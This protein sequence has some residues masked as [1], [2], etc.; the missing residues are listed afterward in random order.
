[1]LM[2]NNFMTQRKFVIN[3]IKK[4]DDGW[5]LY[6]VDDPSLPIFISNKYYSGKMPPFFGG[7][8]KKFRLK[9]S[10]GGFYLLVENEW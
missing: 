6:P 9:F 8:G 1:M 3:K 4:V 10:F 5:N 2:D 7:R